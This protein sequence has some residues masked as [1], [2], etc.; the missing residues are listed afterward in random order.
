MATYRRIQVRKNNMAGV[1]KL[2]SLSHNYTHEIVPMWHWYS[3]KK[4]LMHLTF[5][6]CSLKSQGRTW[7]PIQAITKF[8]YWNKTS[9]AACFFSSIWNCKWELKLITQYR[10]KNCKKSLAHCMVNGNQTLTFQQS[11]VT[12]KIRR[13]LTVHWSRQ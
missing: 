4:S 2:E 13:T 5:I 9:A 7:L 3:K 8:E 10:N 11:V 6:K 12:P 1:L